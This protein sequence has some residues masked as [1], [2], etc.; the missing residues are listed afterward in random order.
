[1]K[2]KLT[3]K[4]FSKPLIAGHTFGN[5]ENCLISFL[6]LNISILA[7]NFNQ[8]QA[9]VSFP[10]PL[11]T[12]EIKNR[13]TKYWFEIGLIWGNLLFWLYPKIYKKLH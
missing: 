12:S 1:M 11:K 7:T 5:Q 10:Y 6:V 3:L 4:R 2:E 9:N 13:K 8:S